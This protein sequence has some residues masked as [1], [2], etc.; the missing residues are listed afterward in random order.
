MFSLSDG[1][2][3]LEVGMWSSSFI[4]LSVR[5][6]LVILALF[7]KK[8]I[9][10]GIVV[11]AVSSC[12]RL[13]P[14][15]REHLISNSEMQYQHLHVITVTVFHS[16]VKLSRLRIQFSQDSIQFPLFTPLLLCHSPPGKLQRTQTYLEIHTEIFIVSHPPRYV[17]VSLL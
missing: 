12:L 7:L 15:C 3:N 11:F 2:S 5:E 6:F 17:W 10:I 13:M 4:W 8:E 1:N 16:F 9:L 14:S